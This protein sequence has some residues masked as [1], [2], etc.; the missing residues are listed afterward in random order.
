MVVLCCRVQ[1]VLT[2]REEALHET[3]HQVSAQV[4][5]V[6]CGPAGLMCSYMCAYM[7]CN[8]PVLF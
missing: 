7:L 8:N 3:Q 5:G 6:G 2:Q 4:G 1:V